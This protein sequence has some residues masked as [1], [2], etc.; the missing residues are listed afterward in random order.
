MTR[1]S[2]PAPQMRHELPRHE[3]VVAALSVAFGL[4]S[5]PAWADTAQAL[6]DTTEAAP[7]RSATLR[8][9]SRSPE[10]TDSAISSA[11]QTEL[12]RSAGSADLAAATLEV[13][14]NEDRLARVAVHTASGETRSR[15]LQLPTDPSSALEVLG[16]VS[17]SLVRSDADALADALRSRNVA[18]QPVAPSA[19]AVPA[20]AAAK[21]PEAAAAKAE[22]QDKGD[23]P[24]TPPKAP[25]AV[26]LAS[27]KPSLRTAPV[28]ASL[29]HPLA[30]LPDSDERR[31]NFELGL[32]YSRV[33][34]VNGFGLSG[35]VLRTEQDVQGAV[36]SGLWS[37]VGGDT[38]GLNV[39]GLFSRS[40]G[41]LEGLSASGV[42]DL[43]SGT[44]LGA[45][46]G[47]V[48]ADNAGTE[49][50]QVGGVFARSRSVLGLQAGG[51]AALGEDATG[52]QVGGVGT[53]A[54]D[55]RGL[56]AGG[57]FAWAENTEGLQVGGVTALADD[58]TGAQIAGVVSSAH[59]VHGTQIGVVNVA[60]R[61]R[62]VQIGVVN[63]ADRVDGFPIGLVNAVGNGRNQLVAWYGGEQMPMN[64]GLKYLHGP[65]YTLLAVGAKP[66]KDDKGDV[67]GAGAGLGAHI[68]L[69]RDAFL[70][71][72]GL[73]MHESRFERNDNGVQTVRGRAA[74]GYQI[75]DKLG[76]FAGGGP[77]FFYEDRP[78]EGVDETGW[79]PHYFAGVQVF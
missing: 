26:P 59:D 76:V 7:T 52:L 68:K 2:A 71:L 30:V 15:E 40:Q 44:V 34:A 8:V 67:Y 23:A 47:G 10:L 77:L 45:Q 48:F 29:V 39:A 37:H 25:D 51:V 79:E 46:F 58:V 73:W 50:I 41:S 24:E 31:I 13:S 78:D 21:P 17:A 3:L 64:L 38:T 42:V 53:V 62:G 72:D 27:S 63:V 18:P 14:V 61:V 60:H 66:S 74:L 11:I 6:P 36:I 20:D 55:L 49:G 28:N 1:I 32:I 43:R 56:Q 19:T 54:S 69:Y 75:T 12:Q 5:T 4:S 70:E 22:P 16:L 35:L 57:V 65:I 9:E 33:G